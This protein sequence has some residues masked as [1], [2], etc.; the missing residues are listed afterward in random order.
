VTWSTFLDGMDDFDDHLSRYLVTLC[1]EFPSLS[2]W[3]VYDLELR[4]YLAFTR[5]ID[6]S[7]Q[8]MRGRGRG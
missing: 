3:N 5:S 2:P 1:H 6:A 7:R 4:H 8:E